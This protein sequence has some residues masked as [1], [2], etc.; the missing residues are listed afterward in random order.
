M[1]ARFQS[2]I[3]KPAS[4]LSKLLMR[5][6]DATG[7]DK[8]KLEQQVRELIASSKAKDGSPQYK[9]HPH[10]KIT[11]DIPTAV[12]QSRARQFLKWRDMW[13]GWDL[14]ADDTDTAYLQKLKRAIGRRMDSRPT[15]AQEK[16]RAAWD[17]RKSELTQQIPLSELQEKFAMMSRRKRLNAEYGQDDAA[18][19]RR[20]KKL[21]R[22]ARRRATMEQKN[23]EYKPVEHFKD[24]PSKKE[25]AARVEEEVQAKAPTRKSGRARKQ[26]ERL[27]AG[28]GG[29]ASK[30]QD[31]ATAGRDDMEPQEGPTAKAKGKVVPRRLMQ[32]QQPKKAASAAPKTGEYG[33]TKQQE[34]RLN[35]LYYGDDDKPPMPM[36]G[37][38]LYKM[39]VKEGDQPSLKSVRAWIADQKVAQ[40]FA[41]RRDDGGEVAPNKMTVPMANLGMDLFTIT[42]QKSRKDKNETEISGREANFYKGYGASG[43]VLV[44]ADLYSRYA[45]TAWLKDKTPETVVKA[46][47][48][49]LDEAEA[50][51]KKT[52]PA[53]ARMIK[54]MRSD[55]GVE[56][57]LA[58]ELFKKKKIHE[59][60]TISGTPS[61]N[62]VTER[63][64]GVLRRNLAK[65]YVIKPR[66]WKT[67]L[68]GV[69]DIYN[70]HWNR[71]LK[72]SPAE[73]VMDKTHAQLEESRAEGRESQVQS[74]TDSKP[75]LK[76]GQLVRLRTKEDQF[77]RSSRQSYYANIMKIK[78]VV[79]PSNRSKAV[80][81]ELEGAE[82]DVTNQ[83]KQLNA[84]F[85]R[86]YLLPIERS[87]DP[88]D[89]TKLS[90][91][92][93]I[94]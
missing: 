94:R 40:V 80:R 44:V 5:H 70:Q 77:N 69:T 39:M 79:N 47:E 2:K 56:F 51:A 78:R 66:N 37:K 62:G 53:K 15:K 36:G 61:A 1:E 10:P 9:P 54:S 28:D 32:Q 81:Y 25:E 71:S 14:D 30:W 38:V 35:A 59:T 6:K 57:L 49:L 18:Y 68:P 74:H 41:F 52:R 50:I 4:E 75:P 92:R 72:N 3:D 65:S 43:Y 93:I 88:K 19:V 63:I 46:L 55:N 26:T 11:D 86:R 34:G 24:L 23:S 48:P 90:K 27:D 73:V 21:I 76:V 8:G 64:V 58:T 89:T 83:D 31:K 67:L 29:P 60:K 33:M 45:L 7:A 16:A 20:L 17:E 84:T 42:N 87:V 12:L 82:G 85:P 22:L 13:Y 91:M